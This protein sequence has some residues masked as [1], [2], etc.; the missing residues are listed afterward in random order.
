MWAAAQ[1]C[2]Q[3]EDKLVVQ[4]DE[5]E[6]VDRVDS[7]HTRYL[8]FKELCKQKGVQ[9]VPETRA[10]IAPDCLWEKICKKNYLAGA[11]YYN[12]EPEYTQLACLFGMDDIKLEAVKEVIIISDTTEKLSSEQPS[13]YEVPDGNEEVNSPNVIPPANV[14]RKLFVD[15]DGPSDR[16]STTEPGIYFID[17]GPDGK[18]RTRLESGRVLPKDHPMNES[19]VKKFDRASN[20]SS[21]GS[22]SPL[23]RWP[24][25]HK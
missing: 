6:L 15:L 23:G 17:V 24:H 21:N 2:K 14:R 12:D 5:F 7:L 22:N 19:N 8:T 11:Y 25:L 3:I 1:L 4:F 18:L 9:W 20:A 10:V 16:E 13:C